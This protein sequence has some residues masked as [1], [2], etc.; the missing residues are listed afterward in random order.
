MAMWWLR[1]AAAL[2]VLA[3]F[4]ADAAITP[5]LAQGADEVA[6]LQAQLRRLS[7]QGKYAEVISVAERYVALIR[8]RRGEEHT[9]FAV[10][11]SWLANAYQ[12]QGRYEDAEP[13]HKRALAI[14]EKAR[15]PGHP[16]VAVQLNNLAELYK[17]QGRYAD[18]EP[19]FKRALAIGEKALGADHPSLGTRLTNL[20]GLYSK[21]GRFGEAEALYKRS[22]AITE[23]ALGSEHTS[24]ANGLNNLALLYVDQ[25]RYVEAEPLYKRALAITEK[26]LGADHP[27][28][29][30]RLNNL[31]GLYKTL[32]RYSEAEA[33]Y[34]RH[35]SIVEKAFGAEHPS[36]GV[37]LNNLALLYL[38]QRRYGDAEPLLKRALGISEKALGPNHPAVGTRLSNL[39]ALYER[40]R[41]FAE[42]EPL[43]SRSL[44]IAETALGPDHPDVA[45]RL[46]YLALVYK[47]EGRSAE[48]EKLF[49][50]ALVITQKAF[51]PEHPAVGTR[52][53][54]LANLYFQQRDWARATEFWRQSARVVVARA[55]RSQDDVGRALIG[56][57]TSEAEQSRNRFVGLV[58][59]AHRLA[60]DTRAADGELLREMFEAAQWANNSEAAASLAQMAARGAK[61]NL[62]LAAV[63]RE[64]QDLIE[65][66]QKRD[67]SRNAAVSRPSD[68]RD[69][70][71]EAGNAA[72]LQAIDT[73]VAE[74]DKQLRA[75]FPD[76]VAFAHPTPLPVA[77]VQA[78]L[79]DGEALLLFLDTR[80][81][82]PV[83]EE[84]FV[85]AVTKQD[86]RWV[87]TG[88]GTTALADAVAT[89]RCGLDAAA[90]EEGGTA[91][92]ASRLKIAPE[93]DANGNRGLPF[94]VARAHAL[95]KALF[96]QV[97]DLI[98][99]KHLLIVPSGPLS[100]LP[101][102]V[103]VSDPGIAG[104]DANYRAAA[105][106]S[107][108]HAIT[109][110]PSVASLRA[111]RRIAKPSAATKAMIGIGNPLLNGPDT[112][113]AQLAKAALEKQQCPK[114]SEPR[115]AGLRAVRS[116]IATVT[117]L[118]GLADVADIRLQSPLPETA[119]E[120]CAVA[121]DLRV[122]NADILLGAR[123]NER[124]IK[125]LSRTGALATYRI[126]HFATHG[127]LAGQL[128][129]GTEPGLILTPPDKGAA[130]DDGYLTAS[131]VAALKLD[132]DWVV[133]SA[134]NTAAG[135]IEG[136]EALSGLARAF[137]YA[138]ARAL[139][140]SHWAVDSAATVKL[141]T[142]AIGT[143]TRDTR[144]GGAEALR[145]A[146]LAM[147]DRGE[148]GQ[149]HPAYWAPFVVV[150]EGAAR[151]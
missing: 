76:Y 97:E 107:R 116:G 148:P 89:L 140:V 118:G 84:T 128:T 77:E 104:G 50:R 106:L 145:Q 27:D 54:N 108:G 34:T 52:L 105:W 67:S 44:Y 22:L 95:Y 37:A 122:P 45:L 59:A 91:K 20:A 46:N 23:K 142:S 135:E 129:P 64:R 127:V 82:E 49:T 103:L 39:A 113:Y 146:M 80:A 110:L 149:A 43:Y 123:A 38:D 57:R 36:V 13:L 75:N 115:T 119:D 86:V 79:R 9:D 25:G 56:K 26:A 98:R 78:Q 139:L 60:G 138:G 3:I 28:L 81:L 85:W 96:G 7:S 133:L 8:Q 132:A 126:V 62:T 30:V 143:M 112:R 29:S 74:I 33:L 72:R 111:L 41:R 124:Q 150:G 65:E 90:W 15:G 87:A 61:D 71:A 14:I 4:F 18:A 117:Q 93:Q 32:G 114:A 69:R 40:Q 121:H 48:A 101:F 63:V 21:Q 2:T 1:R 19:L 12:D 92:C 100:Q 102:Q 147:I 6:E 70:A 31:A 73:R 120:L 141:I 144:V 58:K 35:L 16:D 47:L 10:A 88:M 134:C 83:P 55:G 66:W 5:A 11:L 137:F 131:E 68:K 24:V 125:A 109:V 151:T 17:A 51:G 42:A 53:S 130:E 99:D 94:D 136:A